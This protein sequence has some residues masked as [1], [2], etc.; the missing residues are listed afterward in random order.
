M[1]GLLTRRLLGL[2]PQML[3]DRFNLEDACVL[4]N[5]ILDKTCGAKSPEG[6]IVCGQQWRMVWFVWLQAKSTQESTKSSLDWY[7]IR[8]LKYNHIDFQ[9][10]H[11]H[12]KNA[13]SNLASA[14]FLD[15]FSSY[16]PF[17]E[18]F[19]RSKPDHF[20]WPDVHTYRD[21]D[22]HT[23]FLETLPHNKPFGQWCVFV[24]VMSDVSVSVA[25]KKRSGFERQNVPIKG[26]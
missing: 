11:R 9:R 21:T 8:T 12:L 1:G 13:R 3:Y 4:D 23:W 19:C 16:L 24:C 20:W 14:P 6:H 10:L 25:I 2:I 5:L 15:L 17:I 26:E 18:T 22:G 7:Q